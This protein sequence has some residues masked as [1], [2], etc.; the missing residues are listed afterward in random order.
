MA[1]RKAAIFDL[2]GCVQSPRPLHVFRKYEEFLGLSRDFL[3]NAIVDK[4]PDSALHRAELGRITQTQMLSELQEECQKEASSQ[5]HLLPPQFSVQKLFQD[6]RE[7]LRFNIPI[8]QASAMLRHH[9]VATCV[10]A[11]S[12]VDDSEQR[13]GTARILSVLHTHF[14]LVLQSCHTGTRLPDSTFFDHALQQLGVSSNQVI[15]VSAV[16]AN[17]ATGRDMGMDVVLMDD[18]NEV[19]KQLQTLSGVELLSSEETFPVCCNPED[20]PHC[21][22][23]IKPGVQTHYVDVGEGPAVLLCH[24]FP[25]SWFS[26]RYQIPAL[27]EAGFR[28][29][30][31][32][33]KGYGNSSAPPGDV[34][35]VSSSESRSSG[36]Q[37]LRS[38]GE[39]GNTGA[40]ELRG[41][42]EHGRSSGEHGRSSGAQELR[43][44]GE[45]GN[46][47]AQ[48]LRSSGEHGHTGAQ[49]L[50]SSRAQG[51]MGTWEELRGSGEHGNMGGAQGN[52]GGAQGNMGTQELRSS[53]EHGNTGAQ[54]L[55]S[56]RAQ[57][58]MGTWEELRGSGEHGN[59]GGAQG[60][61]GGAQELRGTW[62]HRSSGAQGNMGTQE[63]RSSRAQG[64]MGTW[65]E[66]RGT[67]EHGRS[68]GAQGN[69]G[70]WELRGTVCCTESRDIQDYSQEQICQG[71]AQVT[72]VGHDWG[73]TLVWN[74]AQHHPERV[75]AV[76]SLNTPLF[77]VDPKTNPMEKIKAIPVFNYQIYFQ[78]PGV[79]E[80]EMEKD[81][82]RIFKI[83]FTGS[84]DSDK[85][86]LINTENVCERG[87]LFVG[88]PD[89]VP[90]S[91][92]LSESALQYYVQQYSKSG[93]RFWSDLQVPNLTRGHIE[94]C[95]HWTQ[96][97]R[98]AELN[99]ILL[100]WLNEVHQKAS[101]PVSPRL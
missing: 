54:E 64:N 14:D 36:E 51:N 48:E 72:L 74:M 12:W 17:L 38:S 29:L 40:Q 39:H 28:A 49:E 100:S 30:V 87:G 53:G 71:V 60:N 57:G 32:D 9:G 79:A 22:V 58:N 6:V 65:E 56:S 41:T 73:G 76:A 93:F 82:E 7:A 84:A 63:L 26:W 50:R 44:S 95:G 101:I 8:L 67:W 34:N 47:G 80:A 92:M 23:T 3:H 81:L 96:M 61:M 52:M 13:A 85:G 66:L 2:W 25:E 33:M 5:G 75:R 94:Q 42:W 20:V 77:P 59:M 55:R 90:R 27:A 18:S 88:L 4:G 91:S 99:K 89:D 16:E 45:H 78:D 10:L 70:T 98:P 83:M 31:P 35:N 19:M 15:F 97:E 62:E 69:M 37:E 11:N 86:L 43:S 1:A 68:S 21:Y 24:G 46:T